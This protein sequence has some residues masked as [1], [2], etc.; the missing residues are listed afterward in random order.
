MTHLRRTAV[1]SSLLLLSTTIA[2]AE[3]VKTANG[4]VEGSTEKDLR[5][6]RGIPFAAPP[7][8]DLRWKAPQPVK[9]WEGVKPAD[10]FG[11]AVHAAPRLRRHDVP[12]RRG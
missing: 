9:N 1:L 7:V 3:P 12:L 4:L 10:K 2:L 8:G 11:R 5:I 6:F